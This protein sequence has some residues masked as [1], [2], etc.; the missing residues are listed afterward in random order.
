MKSILTLAIQKKGRL[1]DLSLDLLRNA[2]FD[3]QY[4]SRDLMAKCKNFPLELLFMRAGDIPEIVSDGVADMGICGE[5]VVWE[6]ELSLNAE[7]KLGWGGCRLSIAGKSNI[8]EGCKLSFLRGKRIATSYPQSLKRFLKEN[9]IQAETVLLSGSVELAPK[10][11]IADCICDLVSTGSTLKVNGLSEWVKIFDSQAV[12]FSRGDWRGIRKKL[13]ESFILRIQ[14]VLKAKKLK[15]VLMNCPESALNDI[16]ALLPGL[17]YPT[18]S[19]LV[20][21]GW[22]SV[23]SVVEED[24]FWETIEALK[25]VGATGIIVTD[26]E[27][28]IL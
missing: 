12:L 5:N 3:F 9:S 11:G 26:I 7:K 16:R 21:E 6:K 18:V 17:K 27:K 20:G 15:Y 28:M 8:E 4:Q 22:L 25:G 1:S 14:S 10:L 2:G 13:F 19:N 23:A 24:R